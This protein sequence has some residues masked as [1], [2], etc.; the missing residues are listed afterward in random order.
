MKGDTVLAV[1]TA[2][3]HVAVALDE[4]KD[5]LEI[6]N[7]RVGEV[8]AAQ[9]PDAELGRLFVRAAHFADTAIAEAED[10]AR[11]VVAAAHRQ[12]QSTLPDARIQAD[13]LIEEGQRSSQLGA[14]AAQ[15]VQVTI[16]GFTRVNQEL[17][18]EL[19]FLRDVI[20]PELTEGTTLRLAPALSWWHLLRN[21]APASRT[22]ASARNDTASVGSDRPTPGTFRQALDRCRPGL[23]RF[24]RR[25]T[26]VAVVGPSQPPRSGARRGEEGQEG[27][28]PATGRRA[29][30]ANPVDCWWEPSGATVRSVAMALGSPIWSTSKSTI[31]LPS[32]ACV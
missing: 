17:M 25:A 9:I 3:T 16:E 18:R 13:A 5:Q 7:R 31:W 26:A 22:G 29:S 11:Q 14:A 8:A 23:D 12:A 4:L 19:E 6:A 28:T 20:Q 30:V 24:R 10:E 1:T 2:V 32:P 27:A 15:Q 21:H